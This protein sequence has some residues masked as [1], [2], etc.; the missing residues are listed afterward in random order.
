MDNSFIVR[1][2]KSCRALAKSFC[3]AIERIRD[4]LVELNVCAEEI[5]KKQKIKQ[6]WIT[7]NKI[8]KP[9]QVIN[10]KPL[11]AKARSNC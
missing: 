10:R 9:H 11:F 7:P 6:S 4:F 3:E 5:D 8:M 1:F 2:E